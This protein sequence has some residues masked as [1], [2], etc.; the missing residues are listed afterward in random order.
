MPVNMILQTK[1][2]LQSSLD[3]LV[4]YVRSKN[5]DLPLDNSQ[6]EESDMKAGTE[7]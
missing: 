2:E 4:S 7:A 1:Q 5:Y 6:K 3:F